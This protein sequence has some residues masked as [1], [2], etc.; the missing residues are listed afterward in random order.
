VFEVAFIADSN[1]AIISE[2]IPFGPPTKW[3]A[4]AWTSLPLSFY[5]LTFG[6]E[7]WR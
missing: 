1:F 6:A 7:A 2:G 3:K 5:V 4:P